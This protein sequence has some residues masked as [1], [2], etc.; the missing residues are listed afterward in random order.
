MLNPFRKMFSSLAAFLMGVHFI[1]GIVSFPVFAYQPIAWW[2]PEYPA[3]VRAIDADPGRLL[4][5]SY[6][7]GSQGERE[8]RL[9]VLM[10]PDGALILRT[11]LPPESMFTIDPETGKE[12]PSTVSITV[13]IR[14]H[15]LD[16]TLDDF[17]FKVGDV[18]VQRD[19]S[20]GEELTSDG[21]VKFRDVPDH[22]FVLA[23]WVI[24]IGFCINHFLHGV[25]SALPRQ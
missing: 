17:R 23:K 2:S 21:F 8:I 20:S 11:E 16:G 15:D 12:I 5:T 1:G 19:S 18:E 22:Q 24:G 4:A 9:F 13:T 14:D 6:R 10:V 25:D 3:L 7:S